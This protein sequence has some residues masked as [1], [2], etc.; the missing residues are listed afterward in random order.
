M[1][2]SS[3]QSRIILFHL[4]AIALAATAVPLANYLVINRSA[5]LF[6]ARILRSHAEQIAD[7]LKKDGQG[8]WRLALPPD[9]S[10]FY[11]QGLEGLSYAVR[12]QDRRLIIISG[13]DSDAALIAPRSSLSQMSR[14]GAQVYAVSVDHDGLSVTVAQNAQ[15]PD[16]IFDDIMADYLSRIGWFTVAILAL[17]LVVDIV[18][19][20][21]ALHPVVRA[22]RIAS[23]ID[24]KRTDLRLPLA[25]LPRELLPLIIAVNEAL[26]RLE[27]GMRLQQEFTADAAHELRTPLA[28]LRA[29]VDS[30]PE[31]KGLGALKSDIDV[32]SHV[33]SQL[34][35]IAELE[36]AS[37]RIDDRVDLY[38]VA[39]DVVSMIAGVAIA[40]G[41]EVALTGGPVLVRGN[42]AMIFRA[43][44]NLADNAI[45]HT[46]SGSEVIVDVR[47]DGTVRVLDKG[48]GVPQ[49]ERALMVRRFWR[50]RRDQDGAGLGL[51]IV[52]RI[53]ELHG[54]K[55]GI[56]DRDGGGAVF[57]LSF[58]TA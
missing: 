19:I 23:A 37:L 33:V 45:K 56:S 3:L 38:A 52:S 30:L 18:I 6:E 29:R 46:E 43:I 16:V 22:S 57:S 41:K 27:K 50:A 28:V 53:A 1:R 35:E 25:G 39:A 26:D 2:I 40:Q 17:L 51:S 12:G 14:D 48:P 47:E 34:L 49:A 21:R 10:A 42:Q 11:G 5:N 24:P 8:Q 9:L 55:L 7:Y 32:M 36:N 15:Y 44:R 20:R 13:K 31:Q 4:L 54:A 58:E